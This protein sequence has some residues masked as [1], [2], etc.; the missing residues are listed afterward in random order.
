VL[1]DRDPRDIDAVTFVR[2]PA[3][4]ADVASALVVP[5]NLKNHAYLK[6]TYYVDHIFLPLK[7]PP[8]GIIKAACYWYGLY[9]HRRDQT[10][11][12]MLVVDLA[13]GA[14]DAEARGVLEGK[15]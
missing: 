9:S 15:T 12:G 13:G 4:Q 8:S 3:S 7:S 5:I 1:E 2:E 6:T 14:D 10:W 11:K